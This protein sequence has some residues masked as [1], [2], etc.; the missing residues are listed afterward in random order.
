MYTIRDMEDIF[1]R[2]DE[3]LRKYNTDY[4]KTFMKPV[5]DALISQV[6]RQLPEEVKAELRIRTPKA[7]R[8]MEKKLGG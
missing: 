3:K 4:Q 6:I 8:N 1:M 7:M 2:A 5:N